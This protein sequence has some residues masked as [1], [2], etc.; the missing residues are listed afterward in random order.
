MQNNDIEVNNLWV[1]PY[2][3]LLLKSY[4]TYINV[5]YCNTVRSIKYICKYINK[6]SDMAVFGVGNVSAST[7]ET[8][9]NQF[10]RYIS[11]Q[12]CHFEF[13]GL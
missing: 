10:G 12:M 11:R 2:S 9:R 1:V 8:E 7:D 3:P 6:G 4:K 5:E 13:K